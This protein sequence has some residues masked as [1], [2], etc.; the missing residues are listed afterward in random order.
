VNRR[1]AGAHRCGVAVLAALLA[2]LALVPSSADAA[3]PEHVY[4][5]TLGSGVF[6]YDIGSGGSL[7]RVQGSPFPAGNDGFGVTAT[8]DR[9]HLYVSNY[10]SRNLSAFAVRETGSLTPIA[11]S[12]FGAPQPVLS[13]VT[14]DGRLLYVASDATNT[15]PGSVSGYRVDQKSGR[16]VPL[17]GGPVRA[18]DQ[19]PFGVAVSPDGEFLYVSNT[20]NSPSAPGSVS[21]YRIDRGTGQLT[22]LTASP[23]RTG[24]AAGGIVMTPDGKRLY[25]ANGESATISAFSRDAGSGALSPVEGS[26]FPAG[27]GEPTG[28]AVTPDGRHL[29]SANGSMVRQADNQV[30]AFTI[31]ASGALKPVPGSPYD[32]GLGPQFIAISGNGTDLYVTNN[33]SQDISGY[34]INASTGALTK[35]ADSPFATGKNPLGITIP[36]EPSN[37]FGFGG[38]KRLKGKPKARLSLD[39]PGPGS[40][41]VAGKGVKN[42]GRNV[43]V[44]EPR[45]LVSANGKVKR[46]FRRRGHASVKVKATFKPDGGSSRTKTKRVRFVKR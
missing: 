7:T 10:N 26:P 5:T 21:A 42:R 1:L 22:E 41:E 29:Y 38:V 14:P 8:P 33:G 17:P 40:A 15:D 25:V 37:E 6:G 18:S 35:L 16:L 27:N 3:S 19:G 44:L 13:A 39:V 46:Q 31:G 23:Y 30:H 32:A 45:L 36:H 9:R 20:G 24:I 43:R 28:L 12:P 4:V 34:A 2:V 11:G